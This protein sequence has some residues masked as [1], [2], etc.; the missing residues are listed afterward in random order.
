MQVTY[1]YSACVGIKTDDT[2]ILCDPWFTQGIYDGSWYQYPELND[3]VEVIGRYEHIYISHIHPDHYDPIFLKNYL[4]MFPK[5]EILIGN[6]KNNYLLKKCIQDGFKAKPVDFYKKGLTEFYI[7]LNGEGIADIDSALVV[8]SANQSVVN[9]NDNRQNDRQIARINEVTKKRPSF[10]LL[11]YAGA[12][13]YPQTYYTDP[14]ELLER[15]VFKREKF[16]ANYFEFKEK[17]GAVKTLPFA[18]KYYLGGSLQHLNKY[19]GVPDAVDIAKVDPDAVVLEDGG[20]AYFDCSS[21]S[22][23]LVRTIPYDTNKI[24]ASLTRRFRPMDYEIDF[25]SLNL[26]KIPFKRLL[27]KAYKNAWSKSQL[28]RDYYFSFDLGHLAFTINANREN[29]LFHEGKSENKPISLVTI[30]PKYFFGLLTGIY[31]WNNAQ[32]GSQ[33]FTKRVPDSFNRDA[34]SFLNFLHL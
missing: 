12:G 23:N 33:Y 13:P 25:K 8:K 26:Q 1:Y 16:I 10:V 20:K 4:K 5:T 17:L 3:P 30:D 32:V 18:G 7:I 24:E 19:R 21:Q 14:D 9:M 34:E 2:S 31:H 29:Y 11:P 15:A 6:W 27:N 28:T 22:A